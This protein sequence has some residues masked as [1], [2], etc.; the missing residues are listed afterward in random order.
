MPSQA[1][2]NNAPN[3]NSQAPR[4]QGQ[5]STAVDSILS[6]IPSSNPNDPMT[7][8]ARALSVMAS[9]L[10]NSTASI[11]D[12]LSA[13]R[14]D[15]ARLKDAAE[16]TE[17]RVDEIDRRVNEVEASNLAA[18]QELRE[19]SA[20]AISTAQNCEPFD[21][22]FSGIPVHNPSN[23]VAVI[24]AIGAAVGIRIDARSVTSVRTRSRPNPGNSQP[25]DAG[26]ALNMQE[27]LQNSSIPLNGRGPDI[28]V[29]FKLA[30]IRSAFLERIWAGRGVD[31][32]SVDP[33]WTGHGRIKAYEVL[34]TERHNLFME[35]RSEA[36][37]RDCRVWH[38]DGVF[39]A[40]RRDGRRI[41]RV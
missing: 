29:T 30:T 26:A 17:K 34:T 38:T 3:P 22:V 28:F 8:F 2:G 7:L 9:S 11:R 40:K 5:I 21:L 32:T 24:C 19:T 18:I 35:L 14:G 25:Q 10:D 15:I 16:T 36:A 12:D 33:G 1:I 27:Q 31:L 20:R 6:A 37:Q 4:K 13:M 23:S 41:R 39:L